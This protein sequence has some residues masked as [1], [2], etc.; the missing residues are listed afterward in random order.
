MKTKL[1]S[2]RQIPEYRERAIDWF[3]SKWGIDRAEYEK[4]FDD[5]LK[6]NGLLPQWYVLLDQNGKIAGGCGL[7][8][9]DFIDRTDLFP[10][11]CAL[12]VEPHA[13]GNALGAVLLDHAR[14]EGARLGFAKLY[15]CTDHTS[16]YERYG[17]RFIGTGRS[18]DGGTARIYEADT[19]AGKLEDMASFFARRADFYDEHMLG[20]VAGCREGYEKMARLIPKNCE[21]LLDLGCGTGLELDEI[22]RRMP[23]VRVT[24][25]D[26]TREM[27]EKLRDK[28]PRENLTLICGDYFKEEFGTKQYECAVSFQTMH[29]FSHE[30]KTALY[31]K[32]C[33]ALK[34]GGVYIE[35]DYMVETQEE[36]NFYFA[37]NT[38]LRKE[39]NIQDNVYAHYDTPCTIANQITMLESAGFQK[40]DA[41][42]RM[43]NTTMIVAKK[44]ERP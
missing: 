13:R 5:C 34:P 37:E 28:H 43:E 40:A 39:Q 12:F 15:L 20:G 33:R 14:R 32:I 35:C 6:R 21:A 27:L 42:F 22:F 24:G 7:I 31:K 16:Y 3:A 11:L 36:E 17:W 2:I 8:Q 44:S 4:S 29:H 10:Y 23:G 18:S 41:V 26:L 19:V 9:N 38:R 1:Y 25:I 30:A